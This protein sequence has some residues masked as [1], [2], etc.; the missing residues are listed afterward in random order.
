[1]LLLGWARVA[2]LGFVQ[3]DRLLPTGWPSATADAALVLFAALAPLHTLVFAVAHGTAAPSPSSDVQVAD[4]H[5]ALRWLQSRA[6]GASAVLHSEALAELQSLNGV[7]VVAHSSGAHAAAL[8]LGERA[9]SDAGVCRGF[10][11]SAVL[12]CGMYDLQRITGFP[13]RQLYLEPAFGT[14]P[15]DWSRRSACGR[16]ACTDVRVPILLAFGEYEYEEL[17]KRGAAEFAGHLIRAEPALAARNVIPFSSQTAG[18]NASERRIASLV[19]RVPRG[20]GLAR[21]TA[22]GAARW[23]QCV[24]DRLSGDVAGARALAGVPRADRPQE[25][26]LR[27]VPLRRGAHAGPTPVHHMR[28]RCTAGPSPRAQIPRFALGGL[29]H[30]WAHGCAR[31]I[32]RATLVLRI[33]VVA[34]C[35]TGIRERAWRPEIR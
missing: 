19:C 23:P 31:S 15:A 1:V 20:F 32:H 8:A 24:G 7:C 33:A 17:F 35:G 18:R 9:L 34:P 12:L 26:L 14:L 2:A 13:W 21:A 5:S 11:R 10:V 16:G 30:A 28:R 6:A 22:H 4:V 27:R 29:A 3:L 25:P